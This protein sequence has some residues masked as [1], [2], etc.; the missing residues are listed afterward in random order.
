[1]EKVPGRVGR[2]EGEGG[3]SC[4]LW[5]IE[6]ELFRAAV[7]Q[8]GIPSDS[9]GTSFSRFQRNHRTGRTEDGSRVNH[10][11]DKIEDPI[12][13]FT[14]DKGYDQNSVYR[15]VLRKNRK[16]KI[17]IHPRVNAGISTKRKW[18]HR[19][20][21]VQKI[22]DDGIYTW[23]RNSGY[24]QQSK[25]ENCIYRYKTIIGR[26]L[27]ARTEEGREVETVIGCN[28]LNRFLELGRC[29]SEMVA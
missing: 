14:G 6:M 19:D 25:V 15:A 3:E 28:I 12:A 7:F 22:F 21:H 8:N 16:A 29:E 4:I 9:L 24:Y 5:L 23:R 20:R 13:S 2:K 10:L 26:K 1:M 18:T 17:V 27:R 11:L